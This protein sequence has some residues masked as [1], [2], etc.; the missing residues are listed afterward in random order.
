[1][2]KFLFLLFVTFLCHPFLAFARPL[3]G[4]HKGPYLAL[5]AGLLQ[6]N[7]DHD[8][9][10][11]NDVGRDFEGAFG[12]LFGWNISDPFAIELGGLYSTDFNV[13][14]REHIVLTT[15]NGR[16]SFIFDPS[17]TAGVS[18]LYHK[19]LSFGLDL[20]EDFLFAESARQNLENAS[21]SQS[22][23]LIYDGGFQPNFSAMFFFGVHY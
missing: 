1:M 8:E 9:Q 13:G 3:K 4:F 14:R 17:L 2:K 16:Y 21:P 20:R 11:G 15:V 7:N 18:F 22:N 5:E 10:A 6:A 12:F 19:Y 23:Q